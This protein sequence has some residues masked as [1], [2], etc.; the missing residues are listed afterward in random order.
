MAV[1]SLP[2]DYPEDINYTEATQTLRFGKG[3]FYPVSPEVWNYSLSGFHVLR[4]WLDYRKKSG[5]GKK[6]SP[7]DLLRPRQWT[8]DLTTE[9]L[10]LIWVLEVT[11]AMTPRLNELL[12][13]RLS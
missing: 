9:L 13:F 3:T 7:L 6:S 2:E 12:R 5:A 10:E 4:S 1:S 11:V 8:A